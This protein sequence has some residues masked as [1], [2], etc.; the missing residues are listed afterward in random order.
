MLTLIEIHSDIAHSLVS[1]FVSHF[2]PTPAHLTWTLIS[3]ADW[4]GLNEASLQ[5]ASSLDVWLWQPY[6]HSTVDRIMIDKI[7]KNSSKCGTEPPEITWKN[8]NALSKVDIH[9][10]STKLDCH[11]FQNKCTSFPL[12]LVGK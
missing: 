8:L 12:V 5:Q 3:P 7:T 4:G 2:S 11:P 10:H 9:N 1:E 6:L